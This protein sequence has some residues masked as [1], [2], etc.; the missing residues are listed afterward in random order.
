MKKLFLI[1]ICSTLATAG[2][3]AQSQSLTLTTSGTGSTSGSFNAGSVFSLDTSL[4]FSGYT[5]NGL[6]YWLQVPTALAPFITITS[7]QY[8]TFTDSNNPGPKTFNS[9]LGANF[10]FLSGQG[11]SD[12]GDLGAT[13]VGAGSDVAAGTYLVTTLSFSL[14][15]SAP[16]GT[17]QIRTTTLSPKISEAGDNTFVAH[18]LP[19]SLYTITVIPE[20]STLALL[21]GGVGL[22][23]ARFVRRNRNA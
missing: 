13:S 5:S 11:A 6:S 17:Y 19:G 10:G 3:F 15:A 22:L 23:A 14:S 18:N 7:E 2:A 16:N 12:S 8:F 4:T 9:S 21:V 1:L 20:P